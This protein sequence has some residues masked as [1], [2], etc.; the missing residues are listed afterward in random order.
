MG[1]IINIGIIAPK[2]YTVGGYDTESFERKSIRKYINAILKYYQE[3]EII[4]ITGLAN[5]V[6]QDFAECCIDNDIKY[7]VYL[8]FQKQEKYWMNPIDTYK[9]LL[10]SSHGIEYISRGEYSPRKMIKKQKFIGQHSDVII[11]IW[12]NLKSNCALLSKLLATNKPIFIIK[13]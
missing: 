9:D 2:T 3:Y 10:D 11:Y 6:E 4:G 13:V 1:K 12:N 8:P 5:G 7:L